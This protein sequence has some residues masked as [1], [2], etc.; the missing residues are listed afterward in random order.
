VDVDKARLASRL[1]EYFDPLVT[2][3]HIRR[4]APDVMRDT[5]RFA[6]AAVRAHLLKR[7][8]LKDNVVRYCYRPFDARW[9]YW[10]PETKLLDEKR[11]EYFPHVFDGNAFLFTTGRTR[12]SVTEP[13]LFTN[14]LNDLNCM[15]S[16]ARGFPLYLRDAVPA[17]LRQDPEDQRTKN[18]S[19]GA[20]EYLTST[21]ANEHALFYHCLA[22]IHSTGYRSSNA[23][24]LRS[25]WPRIPLPK[26]K[27][28]LERSAE[29]GRHAAALLDTERPVPTVT[30]GKKRRELEAIAIVSRAGGGTLNPA[31]GDLDI[32]AGW[33]HAGK[34]RVTMPGKGKLIE[35]D[36]T[37]E[38]LDAIRSGTE[39]LGL[40]FEQAMQC[41][42]ERTNDI[43]LNGTAFWKNVPACVWTYTIGGYQVMKKWLSYREKELLGRGLTKEEAREVMEMAR[44]IGALLLME[45]ALDANYLA[46]KESVFDWQAL[47]AGSPKRDKE[48]Q[49][50]TDCGD[51]PSDAVEPT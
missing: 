23:G 34:D 9:L 30:S 18:L 33:G 3:E 24:G 38:E 44:R 29:L 47:K 43:Y 19:Q 42:G 45:P 11:S 2:D 32:T 48:G 50:H 12:K 5:G 22:L 49:K 6:A 20:V 36:Y 14:L 8:L 35:R 51:R 10:E 39:E 16:G 17:L 25:D 31:S 41:L 27:D 4:T 13:P 40:T 26:T 37:A 7:G 46:I 28:A 21:G 1:A 15:D